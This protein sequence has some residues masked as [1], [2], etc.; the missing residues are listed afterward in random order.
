MLEMLPYPSGDAAH[1]P[2]PQLH[3]GRRAHALPPPQRLASVLRPMGYDSSACRPRT[4]RSAKAATRARSPSATSPTIRQ[5]MQPPRLGDRLGRARSPRTSPSSTAGRSG[6]SCAS[7]SA[8]S[9]TAR[10]RRSTGARTTRRCSRTS[11]WWT[12][13]ASAAAPRSRRATSTQ[14][15]FR[16]TDYAD[17]LL[18]DDGALDWPERSKTIQRNWIGRSRGRRDALPRRRARRGHAG[19]HDP[20]RHALRRHVLRARARAPARR[21]V[22][23]SARGRGV[24]PARRARGRPRSAR[25]PRRRPASS[26]ARYAT[27]P[28]NGEPLPIWVADYVLLDYGTGAIMAVPAHDER[29]LAFARDVTASPCARSSPREGRPGASSHPRC[30]STRAVHRPAAPEAGGRSSSSCEERAAAGPR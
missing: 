23:A 16:I 27:N 25:P 24:R 3:D 8:G 10:R 29:D 5:Q 1:G 15:F 21:A 2:R 7:S 19:L 18:D 13:G 11:R 14:W 17:A 30:S 22:A 20:A 4:P 26:P 9:P 12:A 6:S 28:A